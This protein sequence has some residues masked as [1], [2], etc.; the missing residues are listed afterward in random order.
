MELRNCFSTNHSRTK[1]SLSLHRGQLIIVICIGKNDHRIAF[2]N[3][4]QI[5]K[6][7]AQNADWNEIILLRQR[8]FVSFKW[9]YRRHCHM[10]THA[11]IQTIITIIFRCDCFLLRTQWC[12]ATF[13]LFK[14]AALASY[15]YLF[16]FSFFVLLFF[17]RKESFTLCRCLLWPIWMRCEYFFLK[18]KLQLRA[19]RTFDGQ[20]EHVCS[21]TCR[22]FFC[23]VSLV[24]TISTSRVQPAFLSVGIC[25][26]TFVRRFSFFFFF[27]ILFGIVQILSSH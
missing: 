4:T 13:S 3:F 5:A 25:F 26:V 12:F 14:C 23:S 8:C 21:H 7:Y 10:H 2:A 19:L 15:L 20:F 1:L 11:S 16:S 24:P 18:V 22:F 9:I 6:V 27:A 17:E